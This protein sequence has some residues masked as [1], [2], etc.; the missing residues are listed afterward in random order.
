MDHISVNQSFNSTKMESV[1]PKYISMFVLLVSNLLM[2]LLAIYLQR[3]LKQRTD[4]V[5]A[6]TQRVISC[7]TSGILLGRINAMNLIFSDFQ[8]R[9][10]SNVDI[11]GFFGLCR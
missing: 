8:S 5:L 9:Y 2:T 10:S 7:L 3:Y 4:N 11:T 1:Y 6:I